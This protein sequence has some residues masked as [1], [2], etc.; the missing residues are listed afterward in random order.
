MGEGDTSHTLDF[1]NP[2]NLDLNDGV[3]EQ[4][5]G[6]LTCPDSGM[7]TASYV[8]KGNTDNDGDPSLNDNLFLRQDDA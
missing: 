2:S 1:N 6:S 8:I 3:V 4:L 5:P 7:F